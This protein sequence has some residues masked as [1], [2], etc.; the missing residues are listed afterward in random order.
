M[1]N[2]STQPVLMP[3]VSSEEFQLYLQGQEQNC[4]L[5]DTETIKE[6]IRQKRILER[7]AVK[8]NLK[9]EEMAYKQAIRLTKRTFFE[10][11]GAVWM[12]D[13]NGTG[14]IVREV[15]ALSCLIIGVRRFRREEQD[16][17]LFQLEIKAGETEIFSS[18]YSAELLSSP[19]RLQ[20]TLLCGYDM[21]GSQQ[22]KTAVW[23]WVWTKIV[24]RY[25]DAESHLLPA[26]PGWHRE[27][28][29]YH[30]WA[31]NRSDEL[32]MSREIREYRLR[33]VA[34]QEVRNINRIFEQADDSGRETAGAL[35]LIRL[36][37]LLGRLC[38]EESIPVM[39]V[40]LGS[41]SLEVARKLLGVSASETVINLDAD[42]LGEIRKRVRRLR[43]ESAIFAVTSTGVKSTRNRIRDVSAWV[44]SGYVDGDKVVTP[45]IF[46]TKEVTTSIPLEDSVLL[47][48][49]TISCDDWE[50]PF[51]AV[52]SWWVD[53][54]EN[55]GMLVVRQ[56]QRLTRRKQAEGKCLFRSLIESIEEEMAKLVDYE[57]NAMLFLA[58]KSGLRVIDRQMST[59]HE[60]A[61]T[62][63]HDQVL[64]FAE[65]QVIRFYDR[66]DADL[67]SDGMEVYFDR[68]FY[69]FQN[70]VLKEICNMAKIGTKSL[71]ALKQQL[72]SL[73][74]VKTYRNDGRHNREL[75]V[76]IRIRN[77]KWN[78][79]YLSVLA[80][81]RDFW[82]EDFGICLYERG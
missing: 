73:G 81:R 21:T 36:M 75:Q 13:I 4:M 42:R 60:R 82:D 57:D 39:V 40:L 7:D 12:Q 64:K 6:G 28:E 16:K 18:L 29:R 53:A 2:S 72:V 78:N 8:S 30:F 45:Y 27:E 68:E 9:K 47:D 31:G 50:K 62:L 41:S 3:P 26:L 37:A 24:G 66:E 79:L 46:C 54:V 35:L 63:F 58:L 34:E 59:Q 38:T 32:L 80:I 77:K 67:T 71:L 52:Q 51:T 44:S 19:T 15:P 56:L 55:S 14:Q 48:V 22:D 69:Y 25:N 17:E 43:E 76:D 61:L 49:D 1:H 11:Q 65:N 20:K 5:Y 70:T 23:K 74:L 10:R 33:Y